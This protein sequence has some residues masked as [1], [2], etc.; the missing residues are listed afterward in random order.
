MNGKTRQQRLAGFDDEQGSAAEGGPENATTGRPAGATT[1]VLSLQ[2]QSVYVL[3]SH[4]LIYQVFHALPEMS[5]PAGSAGGRD[6]RLS[7]GRDG[8][9]RQ[10]EARLPALRV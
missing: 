8:H 6:P 5:G 4:S 10:Q 2:G 1:P 9:S 3:D 7:A